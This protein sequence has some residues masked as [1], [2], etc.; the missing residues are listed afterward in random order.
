MAEDNI[1]EKDQKILQNKKN[2][3]DKINGVLFVIKPALL[4]ENWFG[5][6]RFSVIKSEIVPTTPT[7]KFL[8]VLTVVAYV[9]LFSLF[10]RIPTTINGTVLFVDV[11]D[12]IPTAVVLIQY[13]ATVIT[14]AFFMSETTRRII[15]T[16]AD[17]DKKLYINMNHDFYRKSRMTLIRALL[18]LVIISITF[19]LA[20]FFTD[21]EEL[22]RKLITSTLYFEQNLEIFVFCVM[23]RKLKIRLGVMN[24]YLTKFIHDKD[25][26][27]CS[28]FVV[29]EKDIES[30]KQ[31]DF[32]GRISQTNTKIRDLAAMYDTIGDTCRLIN[33]VFNFQIF[34]NLMSTFTYIVITI[35]TSLYYFRK[36]E[37]EAG[38]LLTVFI[39]CLLTIMSVAVMS[40]TCEHL[41]TTRNATKL[42]VNEII[43]DYE[44]PK[45]MRVQAKVFME[46]IEAW[47]LRVFVYDM[48][49]VDI[50]LMLKFI[51]VATTYLI[52][53]IQVSHLI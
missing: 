31:Y 30:E 6:F 19:S 32:I 9:V 48:F 8:G 17:L 28:V 22:V 47:P 44:L 10:F 34:M 12:E 11:L 23:V 36:P 25:T 51:S 5:I 41:L 27:K 52:V 46:L 14:T 16:L 43:M 1:E 38:P 3:G 53:I 33:E 21:K 18:Y 49:S 50:K 39:W 4:V 7:V 40:F 24:G 2:K 13:L 37:D 29:N 35:W 15:S 20:D 42:L 45:T 26:S